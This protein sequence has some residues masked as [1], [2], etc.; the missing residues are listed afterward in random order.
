MVSEVK[1]S[2]ITLCSLLPASAK[3]AGN[4]SCDT[5]LHQFAL[6]VFV[7]KNEVSGYCTTRSLV[8]PGWQ[9]PVLLCHAPRRLTPTRYLWASVWGAQS[10]RSLSNT[11]LMLGNSCSLMRLWLKNYMVGLGKRSLMFWFC[12][13]SPGW[14][15]CCLRGRGGRKKTW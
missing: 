10:T 8:S 1:T 15:S 14:R 9:I 6:E 3:P 13:W 2:E 11:W 5:S 4:L 12:T 7:S